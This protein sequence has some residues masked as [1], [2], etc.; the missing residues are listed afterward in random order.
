MYWF[1]FFQHNSQMRTNILYKTSLHKFN[2]INISLIHKRYLMISNFKPV[3]IK[4]KITQK[5]CL[6]FKNV[7]E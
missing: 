5:R 6:K 2:S 3:F 1:M 7:Y 4:F